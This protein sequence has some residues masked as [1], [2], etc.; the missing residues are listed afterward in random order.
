VDQMQEILSATAPYG[1]ACKRCEN[2]NNYDE[3][4][5]VCTCTPTC[6]SCAAVSEGNHHHELSGA[7]CLD[8]NELLSGTEMPTFVAAGS[9]K[10]GSPY[11]YSSQCG[12]GRTYRTHKRGGS[13]DAILTDLPEPALS[14]VNMGDFSLKCNVE[15][16]GSPS[17]VIYVPPLVDEEERSSLS[18]GAIAGI[19]IGSLAGALLIVALV[20]VSS[21][22]M[23]TNSDVGGVEGFV[24]DRNAGVDVS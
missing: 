16:P 14:L 13:Y 21:K 17:R 15:L 5:G 19:V 1:Q 22:T 4:D 11:P 2:V 20:N 8:L 12:F 7:T 6:G 24:P 23:S 3:A 9:V 18:G 10:Q